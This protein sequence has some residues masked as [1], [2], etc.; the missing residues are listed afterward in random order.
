MCQVL[1]I[2]VNCCRTGNEC[3]YADDS[4]LPIKRV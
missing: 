4:V 2:G 3:V 1:G